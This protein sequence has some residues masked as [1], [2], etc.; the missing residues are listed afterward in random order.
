MP[1]FIS[2]PVKPVSTAR[3][4]DMEM[5]KFVEA[6]VNGGM[7]TSVD[8]NDLPNNV[9]SFAKNAGVRFDRTS[10][11]NGHR[12]FTP[13][14]PNVNKILLLT[15]FDR[16]DGS[17]NFLRFTRNSIHLGTANVWTNIPSAQ[18]LTGL[19][20]DRIYGTV[21][22]DRFFFTNGVDFIQEL[23]LTTSSYAKL[24]NAPVYKY[25]T[26]FNN[27]IIGAHR[28]GAGPNPVEVG[29]SGDLNFGEW[30]P[31]SDFTAGSQP[32]N[33]SPSDLA[34]FITGL[35]SFSNTLVVMRQRS[36]WQATKQPS[37]TAPFYFY[38]TEPG[39]GSDSPN[40]IAKIPHGVCFFDYRTGNIYV[41]TVDGQIQ[42]IGDPII[43]TLLP[44]IEDPA[45]V[46]GSYN[47][48]NQE[49]S[50][51]VT[52]ASSPITRIWTYNFR[53]KVWWYDEI[54]K[55][56]TV[57]N[58]DYSNSSLSVDE[59]IGV[60]DG[61]VGSVDSLV[62]KI[63]TAS[64]FY[65]MIDG[66][67]LV[68]DKE[69]VTDAGVSF[70]TCIDSKLFNIPTDDINLARWRFEIIPYTMGEIQLY[71]SKN[72]V[73]FT[74]AKTY[75]INIAQLKK[76]LLMIVNKHIN[77]RKFMWRLCTSNVKFDI[78]DYEVHVYPGGRSTK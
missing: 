46:T 55:V 51:T 38:N 12:L 64:R 31:L 13:A 33:D 56:V 35:F 44:Q 67:I 2:Q 6:R 17:V 66:D 60:V 30:N 4:N 18:P 42:A 69:A 32:L 72:G 62:N 40:T 48:I 5:A 11:R 57:S 74:F 73:D 28:G 53:S 75:T 68:E 34:D 76:P 59:L 47:S 24:G 58:L 39:L 20:I 7:V 49:Y 70:E 36:I 29:W 37:A 10:R 15:I 65:G 3:T 61:L 16:N 1:K 71:Y 41:F 25:L 78:I 77:T 19:D 50:L 8:A 14:K 54:E 9:L 45:Q 63:R 27:R 26:A 22:N 52:A 23:N 43:K 21:M